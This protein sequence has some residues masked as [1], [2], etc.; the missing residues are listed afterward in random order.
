M[1]ALEKKNSALEIELLKAQKDSNDTIE[2]L[3]EFEEKCSQFQQNVK[4]YSLFYI[5]LINY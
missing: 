2:K 3:R 1:N 5:K 4:R